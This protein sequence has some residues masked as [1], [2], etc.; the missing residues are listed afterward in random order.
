MTNNK[1][2]AQKFQDDFQEATGSNWE[3]KNGVEKLLIANDNYHMAVIEH[4]QHQLTGLKAENSML[5]DRVN[6]QAGVTKEQVEELQEI[7]SDRYAPIKSD[8]IKLRVRAAIKKA[9]G[10]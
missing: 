2:I 4:L 3:I 10:E 9:L 7:L 6:E 1:H 8:I 5:V